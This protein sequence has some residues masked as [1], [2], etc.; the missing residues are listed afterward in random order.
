M[1]PFPH[2]NRKDAMSAPRFTISGP[3]YDGH[4]PF[5]AAALSL[6]INVASGIGRGLSKAERDALGELSVYVRNPQDEVVARVDRDID[7][8]LL[9][10]KVP[11]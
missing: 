6:A 10:F 3:G 9:I 5:E 2:T 8:T 7:G 4:R 11:S 1:E